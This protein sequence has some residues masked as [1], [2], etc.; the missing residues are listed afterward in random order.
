MVAKVK[1]EQ[2][3]VLGA[4][5]R[6]KDWPVG[7][8][9]VNERNARTHSEQQIAQLAA[10]LRSF[11][12]TVPVLVEPDGR[13][14]AG[15]GRVRAAR[16]LGLESVPCLVVEGWSPEQVRAYVIADNKLAQNAGWDEALLATELRELGSVFDPA[17]L[18]F[19]DEELSVL[20]RPAVLEGL[21]PPDAVPDVP[22]DPVSRPGDCWIL[23]AHRAVC[24]DARHKTA[25]EAALNGRVADC[26]WTDP[27]YNVAYEGSAGSIKND[28][29]SAGAFEALLQ[30]AFLAAST[31]LREGGPVYVFHADTEGLAFRRAFRFAG[32]KLS[33]C[34]I[35]VKDSLVLGRSDYQWQHEPCLY[36]WKPGGK[37]R[38]FGGRRQV[39]VQELPSPAF[40]MQE[41]GSIVVR[42]GTEAVRIQGEKLDISIIEGSVMRHPKPSRSAEHPTMK[43]TELIARCLRNSTEPGD[44]VVDMFAGSGSVLIACEQLG[45][46]AAVVELDPR[47][48]DVIVRRWEAFTGKEARL[49]DG[50]TFHAVAAEGRKDD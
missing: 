5:R 26:I 30:A 7:K 41:D 23:G 48:V 35:W 49:A 43:P 25:L 33:G 19:G 15:H 21:T 10:S 8:L 27:P 40:T 50:R 31:V 39:T 9:K 13:I 11:G 22:V 46:V 45:R 37:H 28:A 18:G 16:L 47:F 12:W 34:L 44:V 6:V 17:L 29:L 36:G 38:W 24:G 32:L 14:I 3:A 1:A 20:F 42:V 2:A 4:S